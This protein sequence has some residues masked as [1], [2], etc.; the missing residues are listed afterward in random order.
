MEKVFR[1]SS[2]QAIAIGIRPQVRSFSGRNPAVGT[3]VKWW[4]ERVRRAGRRLALLL[5][6]VA[7]VIGANR[8]GMWFAG[9]R[10]GGPMGHPVS[11]GQLSLR[12]LPA[13]SDFG[14]V[15]ETDAVSI[16]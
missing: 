7:V 14:E 4:K 6:L 11:D 2:I 12:L 13:S 1:I 3:P 10:L 8:A 15:W 9:H 16:R 5:I